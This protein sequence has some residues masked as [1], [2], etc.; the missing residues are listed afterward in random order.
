MSLRYSR[1]VL[2]FFM[3]LLLMMVPPALAAPQADGFVPTATPTYTPTITPTATV[4]IAPAEVTA[5]PSATAT[6]GNQPAP[7]ESTQTQ[8][9]GQAS[10]VPDQSNSTAAAAG[11]SVLGFLLCA[12]VIIV[13]GLA[14]L[15]IW[16]RRRP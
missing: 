12:G 11:S 8:E 15:N 10:N 1:L 2:V 16:A 3:F 6:T 7:L 9:P 14:A 13:A 5:T 4:P